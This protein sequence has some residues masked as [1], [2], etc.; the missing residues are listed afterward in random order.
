M[1][2]LSILFLLL[3]ASSASSQSPQVE[4][5]VPPITSETPWAKNRKSDTEQKKPDRNNLPTSIN[6]SVTGKIQIEESNKWLDPISILTALLACATFILGGFTYKLWQSTHDM[7]EH[8]RKEAQYV[9]RPRIVIRQ[10]GIHKNSNEIGIRY[11]AHNVGECQGTILRRSQHH[12]TASVG[13]PVGTIPFYADSILVNHVLSPGNAIT[14]TYNIPDVTTDMLY[15]YD[16][17]SLSEGRQNK[18]T[19]LFFIGYVEYND[20]VGI[21]RRTAFYRKHAHDTDRFDPIDHPDYEYQD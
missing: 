2:V 14:F 6:L 10:V 13:T 19:D 8:A 18:T 15:T 17:E 3:L 9:H 16:R 1:K 11:T 21:M 20:A 12:W 7:V 4:K 5:P